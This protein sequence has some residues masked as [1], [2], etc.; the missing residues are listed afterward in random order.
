[1]NKALGLTVILMCLALGTWAEDL[2]QTDMGRLS[3]DLGVLFQSISSDIAPQLLQATLSGDIVGEAAFKGDFPHGTLV[4]PGIGVGFGNGLGTVLNNDTP[5]K[6]Q[7]VDL[8]QLVQNNVGSGGGSDLYNASRQIFPYPALSFGLGFGTVKG[9]EVLAEGFYWPQSLSNAIVGYLPSNWNVSGM[10]PEFTATSLLFKV[11]KV[12]MY[13]AGPYPAMSIGLGEL[14]GNF[15]MGMGLNFSND[16]GAN[17]TMNISGQMALE[18]TVLG[19]GLE[20]DISKRLPVITP[21]GSF[22]LWYRYAKASTGSADGSPLLLSITESGTQESVTFSNTFTS[23]DQG[24]DARVSGGFEIR[25]WA[26]IL[27]LSAAFDLEKPL[28]DIQSFSLTGISANGF[29]ISTGIRWAF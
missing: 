14:Y 19:T 22:G 13:D 16:F 1:M 28:L 26:L 24:L 3:D 6:W 7:L 10:N 11:R 23:V 20:F 29:S 9:I 8:S 4:L 12:L 25:L 17:E 15:K 5:D 2:I 27:H 21:F 18:T